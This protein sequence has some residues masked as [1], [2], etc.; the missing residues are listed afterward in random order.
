MGCFS[1][2][3]E[4]LFMPNYILK[5]IQEVKGLGKEDLKHKEMLFSLFRLTY[6]NCYR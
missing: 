4:A 5:A 3:N 6:P 1:S 2:T